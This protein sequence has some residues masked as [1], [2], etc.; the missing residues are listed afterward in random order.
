MTAKRKSKA[1]RQAWW[2]SLTADEREAYIQRTQARR[3][4]RP[5]ATAREATARLELAQLAGCF[6]Y[7]VP[8][9]D[10]AARL[11]EQ[12]GARP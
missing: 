12:E 3:E 1:H 7:E 4:A 11:L 8:D 5:N 6:M 9:S 10:V 2:A